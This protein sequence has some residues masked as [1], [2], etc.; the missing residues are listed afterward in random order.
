MLTD[1]RSNSGIQLFT[2]AAGAA[3]FEGAE[4]SVY[5]PSC[6]NPT[7]ITG[8]RLA[9]PQSSRTILIG[10]NPET[11]TGARF[12]IPDGQKLCAFAA[13]GPLVAV[14]DP[15][16]TTSAIVTWSGFVPYE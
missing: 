16:A 14:A 4:D 7:Q 13:Y 8:P 6:T 9:R 1:Y 3:C 2:V 11:I 15:A 12:W 5:S 10:T